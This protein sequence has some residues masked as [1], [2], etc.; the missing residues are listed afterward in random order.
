MRDD[1]R[2][3]IE[4]R[5]SWRLMQDS[6]YKDLLAAREI[7]AKEKDHKTV[8]VLDEMIAQHKDTI[9]NGLDPKMFSMSRHTT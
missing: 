3:I 9:L 1:I 5:P 8:A 6:V 4:N 2:A 7:A